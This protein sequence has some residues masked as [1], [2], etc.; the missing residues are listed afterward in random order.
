[1]LNDRLE[2]LGDTIKDTI[3]N[4]QEARNRGDSKAEG[5][6]SGTLENQL[7]SKKQIENEKRILEKE[8]GASDLF[9]KYFLSHV[10]SQITGTLAQAGN[11]YMG[12]R[13]ALADGNAIESAI[14]EEKG[15]GQLIGGG[16][17]TALFAGLSLAPLGPAGAGAITNVASPIIDFLSGLGA[18]ITEEDIAYSGQYKKALPAMDM[19]YQRYGTDIEKKSGG[20][21]QGGS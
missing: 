10:G 7:A 1:M 21:Q 16:M 20:K 11:N 12:S 17:K 2:E 9:G 4:I 15:I 3:Q 19:F 6:L 14:M 5:A 13:K 8:N 18:A